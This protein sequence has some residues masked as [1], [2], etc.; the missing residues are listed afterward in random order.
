[1]DFLLSQ[2]QESAVSSPDS[3]TIAELRRGIKVIY[4]KHTP[5]DLEDITVCKNQITRSISKSNN[6]KVALDFIEQSP[7]LIRREAKLEAALH[8]RLWPKL[9]ETHKTVIII[10]DLLNLILESI[11]M[12]RDFVRVQI[13]SSN[14]PDAHIQLYERL[15]RISSGFLE[16]LEGNPQE[17]MAILGHEIGH[18][19][20]A[21]YRLK[22]TSGMSGECFDPCN[23]HVKRFEEEYQADRTSNIINNRLGIEPIYLASALRKME[24]RLHDLFI[25]TAD[26]LNCQQTEYLNISILSTHPHI[27]RRIIS[28]LKNH[29]DLPKYPQKIPLAQIP[30]PERNEFQEPK[31]NEQVTKYAAYPD[32]IWEEMDIPITFKLSSETLGNPLKD[33]HEGSA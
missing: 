4:K 11:G 19:I 28:I 5:S 17:I 21:H 32:C 29:K 26:H 22:N 3:K 7:Q 14:I 24:K 30:I 25:K 13:F 20:L 12:P 23:D 31:L 10:Q 9:P 15:I 6:E 16:T 8:N 1:M 27:N 18:I 33:L 2:P